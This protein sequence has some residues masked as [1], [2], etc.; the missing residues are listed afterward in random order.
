MMTDKEK[1]QVNLEERRKH[2]KTKSKKLQKSI[3]EVSGLF[4]LRYVLANAA[5]GYTRQR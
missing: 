5:V 1:A 3:T 4:S 2:A